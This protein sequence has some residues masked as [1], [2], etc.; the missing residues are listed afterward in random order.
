MKSS[1]SSLIKRGQET[2]QPVLD[3]NPVEFQPH[4]REEAD[5]LHRLSEGITEKQVWLG[6]EI[7]A[8]N[9]PPTHPHGSLSEEPNAEG[10]ELLPEVIKALFN[11][12]KHAQNST[13]FKP[14]EIPSE[15]Y[16]WPTIEKNSDKTTEPEDSSTM[17]QEPAIDLE[18]VE[19]QAQEILERSQQQAQS[20]AH[21]I[22]AASQNQ[23]EEILAQAHKSAE[24][25]I[26]EA[27]NKEEAITQQ[28]YQ[29]GMQTAHQEAV[30]LLAAARDVLNAAQ[31]WHEQVLQHSEDDVLNIMR[32][33]A[34]NLF[35]SG[36]VI[37]EDT[38]REVFLKAMEDAKSLGDLR[39]R[40]NPQDVEAVGKDWVEQQA[41]LKGFQVEIVPSEDIQRGGCYIEGDFG[42]LDARVEKKLE[43]IFE[44][45]EDVHNL[46]PEALADAEEDPSQI[47]SQAVHY[48]S[49][50]PAAAAA[51]IQ[52]AQPDDESDIIDLGAMN[53]PDDAIDLG[54]GTEV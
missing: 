10:E 5:E 9:A 23:G 36:T 18:Q 4:T 33:I 1:T 48:V 30:G 26:Q 52:I 14:N 31:A 29:T 19:K 17:P 21:K 25:V 35:G 2:E 49:S 13:V 47:I 16:I 22:I 34:Q 3:W 50:A 38:L 42:A 11:K 32:A 43:R 51:E 27:K 15:T 37:S 39:L 53:S 20:E 40:A 7:E 46:P 28:A 54:A 44:K 41:E 8:A 45:V 6:Y 24:D 12:R